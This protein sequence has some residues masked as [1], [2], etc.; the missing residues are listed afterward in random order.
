MRR[1][2]TVSG[3]TRGSTSAT[4]W[5]DVAVDIAVRIVVSVG[6]VS[7]LRVIG[8]VVSSLRTIASVVGALRVITS[9]DRISFAAVFVRTITPI[10]TLGTVT[11]S[12]DFVPY[13][14]QFRLDV[15]FGG[16][17]FGLGVVGP[18]SAAV[19]DSP[20]TFLPSF[21]VDRD[22]DLAGNAASLPFSLLSLSVSLFPFW[23]RQRGVV[24]TVPV[25]VGVALAPGLG[26]P[27]GDLSGEPLGLLDQFA[28]GAIVR[29][30]G[31]RK[32]GL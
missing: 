16:V 2:L 15:D 6:A 9:V 5:T 8:S 11:A 27:I 24:P 10:R 22:V 31:L 7:V 3:T 19:V 14:R 26:Q 23:P 32:G 1:R 29:Q 28:R 25:S 17:R 13:R 12:L 18:R 4:G 21:V 30:V 20:P